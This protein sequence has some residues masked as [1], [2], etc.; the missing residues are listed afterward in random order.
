MGGGVNE[1]ESVFICVCVYICI[2]KRYEYRSYLVAVLITNLAQ[3]L[4]TRRCAGGVMN[5]SL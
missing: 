2:E 3:I 5:R 1:R 4:F